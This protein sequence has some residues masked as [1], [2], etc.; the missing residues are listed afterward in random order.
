MT[1]R[2]CKKIAEDTLAANKVG[3]I[4]I[5]NWDFELNSL[6]IAAFSALYTGSREAEI[7]K[8]NQEVVDL[9]KELNKAKADLSRA[10]LDLSRFRSYGQRDF[11]PRDFQPRAFQPRYWES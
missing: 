3:Y 7:R 1:F 11:Q 4:D 6:Q 2:D 5:A 8:K 10:E 9:R